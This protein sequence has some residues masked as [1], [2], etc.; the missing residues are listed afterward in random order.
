MPQQSLKTA[1]PSATR[2]NRVKSSGKNPF[3]ARE[4]EFY[5]NVAQ[6]LSQEQGSKDVANKRGQKLKSK[7]G[8][9]VLSN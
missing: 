4:S 2:K 9:A 3:T 6:K 8:A 1:P 5:R 7:T